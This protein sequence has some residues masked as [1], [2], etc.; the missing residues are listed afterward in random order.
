MTDDG[1]RA[2][3]KQGKDKLQ[4]IE[5]GPRGGGS[6]YLKTR[7]TKSARMKGLWF[8]QWYGE[9]NKKNKM[10]LGKIQLI[11]KPKVN[12]PDVMELVFDGMTYMEA[13]EAFLATSKILLDGQDPREVRAHAQEQTRAD[14][15]KNLTFKEFV[16]DHYKPDLDPKKK[17]RA[18]ET[19][20]GFL[21][22]WI[23]P[24]IGQKSIQAIT[25]GDLATIERTILS[26]GLSVR[27]VQYCLAIVRQVLNHAINL[28]F[29]DK[30]NPV[31]K[32]RIKTPNNKRT[33]FLT[34]DEARQLMEALRERSTDLHDMALLSLHCGLRAGETFALRWEHVDLAEK[35]IQ[36][37]DAKGNKDR[38]AYMS[39]DVHAMLSARQHVST[40]DLV[41][42]TRAGNQ[43]TW[44]SQAFRQIVRDLGLNAGRSDRR[45]HV[46][47]HTLRHT[48][49]SWQV[50]AG[51]SLY[52][53]QHLLGHSTITMTQ[54]YAHLAPENL[55]KAT[56]IFDKPEG[57]IVPF[58]T[59]KAVNG[60][61]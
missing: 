30:K 23:F 10:Q 43:K 11:W 32:Y 39:E 45:D 36:I 28:D 13:R 41:F 38:T 6:L 17:P 42:P 3:L 19:E 49:A 22:K 4:Q 57:K 47:F 12:D 18:V 9:A 21:R 31:S 52:E 53:L 20:A 1:I 25:Y 34:R 7:A 8:L 5:R 55:R 35:T 61:E 37:R 15:A 59:P 48:F 33:R 40:T 54:R 26:N 29:F 60:Q 51:M 16:A 50:Q 46:C 44:V 27:T 2:I 58:P 14:K 56:A 24:I